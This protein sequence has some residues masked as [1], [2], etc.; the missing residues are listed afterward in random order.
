MN[1]QP[2]PQGGHGAG[3]SGTGQG[4]SFLQMTPQFYGAN[5]NASQNQ[6]IVPW[7]HDVPVSWQPGSYNPNAFYGQ[8]QIVQQVQ[9]APVQLVGS[10]FYP[11]NYNVPGIQPIP[12]AN[13]YSV[14]SEEGSY[15]PL[16]SESDED[17]RPV[18]PCVVEGLIQEDLQMPK[19]GLNPSLG[20]KR[21]DISPNSE[22][23]PQQAKRQNAHL[24][25]SIPSQ[26]VSFKNQTID[27]PQ[28]ELLSSMIDV[29]VSDENKQ[30]PDDYQIVKSLKEVLKSR[31]FEFEVNRVRDKMTVYLMDEE[32]SKIVQQMNIVAGVNVTGSVKQRLSRGI[33][34]GVQLSMTDEEILECMESPIKIKEVHRQKWYN[35]ETKKLSDSYAIM[36]V[37]EGNCLPPSVWFCGR[38]REVQVYNR[39][40]LQCHKCQK[41]GH[42]QD[43]CRAQ[44]HTCLRC[45]G[46]HSS[47][48]CH[49]KNTDST[50]RP[51]SY[52]C[53]NCKGN[54]SSTSFACPVRIQNREILQ[55]AEKYHMGF[56]RAQVTYRSYADVANKKLT[57][58]TPYFN[59]LHNEITINMKQEIEQKA[60]KSLIIGLLLRPEMLK[61]SELSL[62][63]RISKLCTLVHELQLGQLNKDEIRSVCLINETAAQQYGP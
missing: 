29:T 21:R 19:L 14:L 30:L 1:I 13:R 47:D 9:R 44:A 53:A 32:S 45:S 51:K 60:A 55:V 40:L 11:P 57:V 48:M 36:V 18:N 58:S 50:S 33:I 39:R 49:L 27:I 7:S 2:G 15:P 42:K 38:K 61:L 59:Q 34:K 46:N 62:I 28:T 35:K 56:K 17:M 31:K 63:E 52:I 41:Y 23:A 5:N 20:R 26:K 43:V 16:P 8:Q 4:Q 3:G 54:H 12:L 6:I 25:Q 24:N 22:I 37:F 10:G